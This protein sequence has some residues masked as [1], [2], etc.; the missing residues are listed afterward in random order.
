MNKL[1]ENLRIN[2]KRMKK[3]FDSLASIGQTANG[4]VHRP[5]FSQAHLE[6]R[7]WFKKRALRLGFD[8]TI[9]GA[10]N[11]AIYHHCGPA[12]TSTILMGSHLDSVPCGGRFDGAL[13][14]VAAL[15]VIEVVKEN[16]IK[17][18][19][20]LGAVDFT[21]EEGTFVGLMGSRAMA[22]ILPA[23]EL[24]QT[25]G[26]EGEFGL[27]L[28][29]AGITRNRI[30]SAS[31]T[32]E[33]IA[34]YLELHVEQGL[35]LKDNRVDI[36]VV[37]GIVG[38]RSFR[39]TFTGRSDH[40]GTTPMNQRKDP[41]LVAAAFA[42][43]SRELVMKNFPDLVITIGDM[44][45]LPGAFNVVPE[46]VTVCIEFRADTVE[47]FDKM[48]AAVLNQAKMEAG[49]VDLDFKV[50][51]LERTLPKSTDKLFQKA[52]AGSADIL[53]LKRQTMASGAGHD[54]QA[55]AQI[56]PMGMIFVPSE[57][58]SSHSEREFTRWKDCEN[59]ANVLLHTA[60]KL[61]G[62]KSE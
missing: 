53:G 62:K 33:P 25:I 3:D 43:S 40:A 30:L 46:S 56:C 8:T 4:G 24:L 29:H 59:G 44:N 48:E 37:T 35:K 50:Q 36:G 7:E 22:G 20:H 39:I 60:I 52:I 14:V 10:G 61:A 26:D 38:I 47:T 42:L 45:F 17:L 9:D 31:Q 19:R 6:A 23:E 18:G 15:E 41:V 2:S 51:K 34:G 55:M 16:N 1:I 21:D 11:H 12:E 27:A 58:G 28:E 54:A 32:R 57:K 13:G 5:T 49:R